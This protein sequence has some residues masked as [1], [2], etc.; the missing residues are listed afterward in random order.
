VF[1][2]LSF[3]TSR[4]NLPEEREPFR[5][6]DKNGNPVLC[7]RC[8]QS[9]LPERESNMR[10]NGR[11]LRSRK[12]TAK[13]PEPEEL[14]KSIASCDYCSLHWHLDCL[15]PPLSAMPPAHKK[16][17]CPAHVD[18]VAVSLVSCSPPF[19]SAYFHDA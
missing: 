1:F 17:M 18:H 13:D 5:L 7:F 8:K 16:W 2:F 6:K 4:F 19:F 14:W 11:E 9:A 10:S 3:R 15:E 12:S